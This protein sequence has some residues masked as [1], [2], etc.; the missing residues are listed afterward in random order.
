MKWHLVTPPEHLC[1]FTSDAI[2]NSLQQVGF[3]VL[4]V[5]RIGKRFTLQYVVQTLANNQPL[6]TW[7]YAGAILRRSSL[8]R[9]GISINLRDNIFVVA[10]KK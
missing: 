1:L 8:G 9:L 7:D 5:R 6:Q 3:E 4:A 10:R 2:K